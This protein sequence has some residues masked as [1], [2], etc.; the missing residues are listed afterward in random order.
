MINDFLEWDMN[1]L[2][3]QQVEQLHALKILCTKRM[4]KCGIQRIKSTETAEMLRT[5]E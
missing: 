3:L 1:H 2:T 5:I 4:G